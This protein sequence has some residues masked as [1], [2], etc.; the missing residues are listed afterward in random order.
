MGTIIIFNTLVYF[1]FISVLIHGFDKIKNFESIDLEPRN[2]FTIIVPFRNERESTSLL[3][4]SKMNYPMHWINV[5]L[6]DD[7]SKKSFSKFQVS[8]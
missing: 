1:T 8:N 3:I 7:E 5:I 2:K 6:V 4:A